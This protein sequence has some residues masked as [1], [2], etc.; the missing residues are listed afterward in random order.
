[1]DRIFANFSITTAFGLA[2]ILAFAQPVL[3]DSFVISSDTT[4][5]NGGNTIDGGDTITINS[6]VTVDHTG[7]ATLSAIN[8]TGGANNVINNGTIIGNGTADGSG[9]VLNGSSSSLN[10]AGSIR[11]SSAGSHAVATFGFN[12]ELTNSGTIST[13]GDASHGV[14][15]DQASAELI[16]SGTISVSGI[17]SNAVH[18]DSASESYSTNGKTIS[19]NGQA[20]Y[21]GGAENDLTLTAP[22]YIEGGITLG[23][24]SFVTINTG[25]S[26]SF[27]WTFD[28]AAWNSMTINGSVPTVIS[29]TTVASIDPTM[30][31]DA[32][33]GMSETV[34]QVFDSISERAQTIFPG[35][36]RGLSVSTKL[37]QVPDDPIV[38]AP[39]STNKWGSGFGG[40]TAHAASGVNLAYTTAQVGKVAGMDWATSPDQIFGITAGGNVSWFAA[41]AAFMASHRIRTVG[42]FIGAYCARILGAAVLDY[43]LLGGVQSHAS[44][45]SINNN[46]L[47]GGVDTGVASYASYY[48]APK[49]ALRRTY[50]VRDD[51]S[52]T[53]SGSLGYVAGRVNGYSETATASTATFGARSFGLATAQATLTVIKYIGATSISGKFGVVARNGFGDETITG[54]L[55]G[56]AWSY[57]TANQNGFSGL[58]GLA[59]KHQFKPSINGKISANANIGSTGLANIAA[60][61][62]LRIEF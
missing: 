58:V 39:A 31:N 60:S 38:A 43:A 20:I 10:N 48:I 18:F 57:T 12:A 3:A 22:A 13:S 30:F 14:Y 24:S 27:Q 32:T 36:T 1:M 61:A 17:G 9:V 23:S 34:D 54:T 25:R 40:V 16:N 11:T 51:L 37:G 42:G 6:G 33:S 4:D 47:V 35:A 7:Q 50:A 55:L 46:L 19:E 5:T 56:Q 29:G 59:L 45:R 15:M 41:D 53:T 28:G 44:Q 8:T 62:S 2:S 52:L 21:F 26:H 49:V